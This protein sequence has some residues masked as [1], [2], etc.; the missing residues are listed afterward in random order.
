MSEPKT[1]KEILAALYAEMLGINGNGGL[2]GDIAEVK[3][4]IKAVRENGEKG[5]K[6]LHEKVDVIED[7]VGRLEATAVKKNDCLMIR[8]KT[9]KEGRNLRDRSFMWVKDLV[10]L[11]VALLGVA[12]GLGWI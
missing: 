6:R 8:E 3:V 4:E 11:L 2:R 9:K 12:I 7:K 1:Q 10:L 5:R